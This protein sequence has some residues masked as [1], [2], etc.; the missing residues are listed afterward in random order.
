[1]ARFGRARDLF[2]KTAWD[3]SRLP[4]DWPA[5]LNRARAVFVPSRFAARVFRRSG[6]TV[7]VVVVPEGVDPDVYPYLD[8]VERPG[9]VTLIVGVLAPRKNFRD[10]I[11]A[12]KL[13]FGDDP[14][15]RL[16]LK[17]RF[18]LERYVPDDPRIQVVDS[19]ETTR[20]IAHWYRRADVLLALGNEGFGLPLVEGMATGLPAVALDTEAQAD[21]CADAAGMVL[22]VPAASW[23]SVDAALYGPSGVRAVPDIAAAA[24]RL[25]WVAEHRDEA[26]AM[27][28]RASQWVHAHRNVWDLGPATLDAIERH[29]Q[30]SG[31]LRRRFAVWAGA[32]TTRAGYR[33]YADDLVRLVSPARL[34]GRP[35]RAW[36]SRVLHVQH[37]PGLLADAEVTAQLAAARSEGVCVIVTEHAVGEVA[38]AWEQG[39]DVLVALDERAGV[40]LRQRW[41]GKRVEIIPRG[42]PPW[43]TPTR[44]GSR[45]T[46][47]TIGMPSE[48]DVTDWE[49]LTDLAATS[50]LRII[51]IGGRRDPSPPTSEALAQR[52]NSEADLIVV[53][54]TDDEGVDLPCLV[55]VA[56]ASGVPVLL[57]RGVI[58]CDDLAGVTDQPEDL[59]A[60]VVPILAGD[61]DDSRHAAAARE[62]CAA[63][64][65]PRIAA[66]HEALWQAVSA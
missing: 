49:E 63:V 6:V 35:P 7:P 36:R 15:A 5:R 64:N 66:L 13:A 52:L 22:P 25:R 38:T 23:V 44:D 58:A 21:V 31:P 33:Y 30:T 14:D 40:R 9:V 53:W 3:S 48:A 28:R 51:A 39:A 18:Q 19:N 4:R 16:I 41:P 17:A 8:R 29:A 50:G 20:G 61:R 37:A 32:T 26:R 10:G 1:M 65:W 43:L 55:R 45:R 42:C 12:W 54:G 34:Y 46:I 47:A 27:G 57:G 56:I 11:A 59:V 60:S 2:I 24:R 62:F